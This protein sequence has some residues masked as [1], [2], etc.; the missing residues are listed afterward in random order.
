MLEKNI[1]FLDNFVGLDSPAETRL[2]EKVAVCG[3]DP[4]PLKKSD[5]D[6]NIELLPTTTTLLALILHKI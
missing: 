3:F 4:Y 1:Q 2:R 5:F 6:G